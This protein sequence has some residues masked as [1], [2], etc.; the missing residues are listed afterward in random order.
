MSDVPLKT[1][2][3]PEVLRALYELHRRQN[4]PTLLKD[5]FEEQTA[6][7]VDPS[8]FKAALC[9]RRAGK[10]TAVAIMMCREGMEHPQCTITYVA[11]TLQTAAKM[12]IK[13][14]LKPLNR[15]FK[16]GLEFYTSPYKV[17]FPNGSVIYLVGADASEA[18]RDKLLGQK[19]RIVV[20]DEAEAFKTDLEKIVAGLIPSLLDLEGTIVLIGTPHDNTNS[21]FYRVTTDQVPGWSLHKWRS[22]A[23]PFTRRQWLEEVERQTKLNKSIWSTPAFKQHYLGEWSVDPERLVYHYA[24]INEIA[25]LPD[26]LSKDDL[27]YLLGVDFGYNDPT[28]FVVGAYSRTDPNLYILETYKASKLDFT[29][30]AQHIKQYQTRYHFSR[31][32]VDAAGLQGIEELRQRHNLPLI[33]AKKTAKLDYIALMNADLSQG[34]V[35]IMRPGCDALLKEWDGIIW[36]PNKDKLETYYLCQDHLSDAALYMWRESGHFRTS[37]KAPDA[38]KA[39]KSWGEGAIERAKKN[40][41]GNWLKEM[42]K[43][44]E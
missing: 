1:E 37:N 25:A 11:K 32:V 16:L 8:R 42:A 33:A 30:V 4:L 14:V 27:T 3:A 20:I 15:K 24:P 40:I 35:K 39:E 43:Q 23:N 2:Y 31:I 5:S 26:H 7:I 13:D 34:L 19:N 9:S 6:F 22:D 38:P 21:F 29:A 10:T 41:V 17:V 18:E 36:D 28:A 12:L 44:Y